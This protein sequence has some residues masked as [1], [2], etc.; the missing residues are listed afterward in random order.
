MP[1]DFESNSEKVTTGTKMSPNRIYGKTRKT[2]IIYIYY[3]LILQYLNNYHFLH[4]FTIN[5]GLCERLRRTLAS[6]RD[7]K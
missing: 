1:Y 7:R 2:C 4:P 3:S 6:R 5:Y